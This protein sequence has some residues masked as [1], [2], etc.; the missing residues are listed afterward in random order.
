MYKIGIIGD[1]DTV[2]AFKALGIDTFPVEDTEQAKNILHKTAGE[3]YG[4]VFLTEQLAQDMEETLERY[5]TQML[6][7]IILI[8]NNKGSLGLGLENIQ[9]S[10]EK[11]IGVD[12]LS[13][14]GEDEE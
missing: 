13:E 10:V 14:E 12:I 2:L 11:A 4:V 6:P 8:P 7:S 3:D 1:E 9:S 5:Y